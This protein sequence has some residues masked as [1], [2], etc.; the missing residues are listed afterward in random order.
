VAGVVY[1]F[2]SFELDSAARALTRNGL[3]VP[4]AERHFD[5]LLRL[6]AQAGA[7]VSKDALV[8]AGWGDVA[9]TDNSLEQAVSA[10]RRLLG[11]GPQAQPCIQTVPRQGY[12]FAAAVN[13]TVARASDEA[14]E[15][16]LTPHRVWLEGRA[17]VETLER[18]QVT[19]AQQAFRR[20][21]DVEPDHAPAH[22][23]LANACAFRFEATRADEQ[24][25]L[26]ALL[27]ALAHAREACRLDSSSGEAWATLGF[28][29]HR[30]GAVEQATAAARRAIALEPDNWR[31]HL[32]LGFVSW[33]EERLRASGRALQLLPGL[34]L[35]HWLAAT[36]YVAR[37]AFDAAER[38]L[39]AGAAAQ[40]A[41]ETAAGRFGAVGLH[42]LRGLVRLRR[43]DPQGALAAFRREL[44]FESRGHLYAREC[45]ANTWYA[46]AALSC[47][48]GERLEALPALDQALTRVPGH[49]AALAARGA[50]VGDAGRGPLAGELDA[51]LA[52]L[53][54]R[55][56][57]VDAALAEA[58]AIALDGDDSI[59]AARA[60]ATVQRALMIGPNGSAGWAIPVDPFLRV[61]EHELEWAQVL[62]TLRRLAA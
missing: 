18:D 49:V 2:G 21:L 29:L 33:G 53:R 27:D 60:A 38:E 14:L 40:D 59:S 58:V 34:A 62:A 17:A 9:V 54:Q 24:P 48:E 7:V 45:G 30:T 32:R 28:V 50:L 42:W 22:I 13:R 12:R 47:R 4:L 31:H 3:R 52:T 55:G 57:Q 36:V 35:A 56:A 20:V 39:D 26:A 37:Q 41:E 11:E 19:A 16:L 25:D 51:R 5:V 8:E 43:G 10:L 15:A 23:G 44:A 61:F 46:L 6:V 1:S